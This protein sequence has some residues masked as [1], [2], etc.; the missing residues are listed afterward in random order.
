AR[1]GGAKVVLNRVNLENN[2]VGLRVDATPWAQDGAYVVLR[3]SVVSGNYSDG[4]QAIS[5]PGAAPAFIAVEHSS[6]VNNA[7]TGIRADGPRATM[8]LNDNTV[9]RNGVGISAVNS[10]QLISYGNNKVNNNLGPDGTPT[11]NYSPI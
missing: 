8:L 1:A 9:A 10:G 7:G 4:I 11:G 2:V 5:A 3:D 6:I